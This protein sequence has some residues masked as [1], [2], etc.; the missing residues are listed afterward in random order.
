M[1]QRRLTNLRLNLG[2][3][4]LAP[5]AWPVHT[6][7]C[8]CDCGLA[9]ARQHCP[10]K[11]D[12]KSPKY[13]KFTNDMVGPLNFRTLALRHVLLSLGASALLTGSCTVK[14]SETVAAT[15]SLA[16]TLAFAVLDGGL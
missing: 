8:D 7:S 4:A 13:A 3:L 12:R 16:T 2:L 15:C 10:K 6:S 5:N 1:A 14:F 11:K 9:P